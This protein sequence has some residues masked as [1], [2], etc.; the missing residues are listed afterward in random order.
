MRLCSICEKRPAKRACPALASSICPVCC[1]RDRMIKLK[2]PE[3]CEYLQ[4]GRKT[5]IEKIGQE[6]IRFIEQQGI[7][8]D[9]KIATSMR[10]MMIFEGAIVETQRME[11]KSLKDQDIADGIDT[12]IRTLGTF[13][14][15]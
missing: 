7:S 10:T 1:A 12:A 15:G 13:E 9:Q 14:S 4:S 5:A 6:R 3:S 8:Y 2:C 11:F